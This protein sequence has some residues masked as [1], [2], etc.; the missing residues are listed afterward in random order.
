M[1]QLK[2]FEREFSQSADPRLLPSLLERLLGTPARLEEKLTGISPEWLTT[3]VDGTWT[4]QENVGHLAD[5]E[6]LWLGRLEDIVNGEAELRPTDLS[7][8]ATTLA[9][10]NAT[11]PQVLLQSFRQQ[12]LRAVQRLQEVDDAVLHRS[13]LHPRMCTP[14]RP[15]D[16]FLFVAEHD[17]HHLA[18]ISALARQL[19]GQQSERAVSSTAAATSN[20]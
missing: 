6:P 20:L 1:K 10:H 11:P 2:W 13:A 17:D 12:R 19:A 4:I 9:N 16:L 7:N 18:R 14:M 3:W 8:E 5:L 15:M